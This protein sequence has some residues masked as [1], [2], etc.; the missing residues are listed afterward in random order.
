MGWGGVDS[1][2]L[3]AAWIPAV[4]TLQTYRGEDFNCEKYTDTMIRVILE[5]TLPNHVQEDGWD[6]CNK[7]T[8]KGKEYSGETRGQGAIN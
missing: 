7:D 6:I 4:W 5:A 1:I 3:Q 2:P 8:G